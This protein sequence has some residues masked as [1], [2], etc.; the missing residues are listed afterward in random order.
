LIQGTYCRVERNHVRMREFGAPDGLGI[1]A[2][3]VNPGKNIVIPDNVTGFDGG[4][5]TA[6]TA[7]DGDDYSGGLGAADNNYFQ[8]K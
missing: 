6:N 3:V 8:P 7:L 2:A 4:L 5:H 1:K